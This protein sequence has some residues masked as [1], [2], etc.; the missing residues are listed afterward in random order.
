MT[1]IFVKGLASFLLAFGWFCFSVSLSYPFVPNSFIYDIL[2]E[3]PIS[4]EFLGS[5]GAA[6]IAWSLM[7]FNAD[8]ASVK[9]IAMASAVGLMSL[10]VVRI[11]TLWLFD[12]PSS[13]EA[14]L[15]PE[16]LT[17]GSLATAVYVIGLG[18]TQIVSR[19]V[20]GAKSLWGAPRWVFWW[21]MAVLT[22]ANMGGFLFLDHPVGVAMSISIIVVILWNVPMLIMQRGI[23]RATSIPHLVPFALAVAYTLGALFGLVG[24]KAAIAPGSAL[25]YFAWFY[26]VVNVISIIFDAID[27]VRWVAGDRATIPPRS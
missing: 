25:F 14:L 10:S 1:H 18:D 12:A 15:V 20:D 8:N 16:L 19:F 22:P 24:D 17:F 6:L 2:S 5:G 7:L 3:G 11:V 4:M 21:V 26:V 23:S 9:T 27:S 13:F